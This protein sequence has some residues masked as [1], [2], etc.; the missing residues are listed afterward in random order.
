MFANATFDDWQKITGPKMQAAWHIHHLLRDLKFF[1]ALGSVEALTGNLGQ[2]IYSGTSVRIVKQDSGSFFLTNLRT[3]LQTFMDAF[4]NYRTSLN[5]PSTSVHLPVVEDVG[6]VAKLGIFE[7]MRE[8]LGLTITP[9]QLRTVIKAAIIGP[10]SGLSASDQI[11][12]F[13]RSTVPAAEPEEPWERFNALWAMRR[14]RQIEN[15]NGTADGPNGRTKASGQPASVLDALR[16]K[17]ATITLMEEDEVTADRPLQDYGLD[18]LVSVEL[19]NWIRRELGF[20]MALTQIS[21]AKDLQDLGN[22]IMKG[23]GMVA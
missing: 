21:R 19:R 14:R 18:S 2:S 12:C 6:Y 1:V 5:L 8:S 10:N 16:S 7:S 20:D 15:G 22:T 13:V 17:V 23:I 3:F 11:T 9:A 4:V